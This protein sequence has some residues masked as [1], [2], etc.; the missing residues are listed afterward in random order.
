MTNK[1]I[2]RKILLILFPFLLLEIVLR[3]IGIGGSLV[4][5]EHPEYGYAPAPSQSFSTMGHRIEILD[6]GF[7]GPPATN[8]ILFV[9]DSVTYGTAFLRDADTF[10]ALLGGSNAGV[11]GWGI[12]NIASYLGHISLENYDVVVWTLPS[13][14]TLRPLMT[15]RDG[16]ISSN[17]RMWLRLEYIGRFIWYGFIQTSVAQNDPSVLPENIKLLLEAD[18]QLTAKGKKLLV[19]FLPYRE[20]MLGGEMPETPYFGQLKVAADEAGIWNIRAEYTGDP[21]TLFRDS[22]HLSVYGNQW[23]AG[24]IADALTRKSDT[25]N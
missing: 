7:R 25:E 15:L 16:L 19:V 5:V 1:N 14:D 20:E 17:R 22:A 3:I 24:L 11:N 12:P 13:C 4:Y 8:R 2:T 23:L 21:T 10:P 9:G 18:R 6:N